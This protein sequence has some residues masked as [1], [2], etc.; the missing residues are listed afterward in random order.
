MD[1]FIMFIYMLISL[2][3]AIP[4]PT[5]IPIGAGRG[6]ARALKGSGQRQR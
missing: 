4:G 1:V 2:S 3:H 6:R 5:H